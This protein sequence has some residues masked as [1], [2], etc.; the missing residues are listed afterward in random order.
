[1]A[2]FNRRMAVRVAALNLRQ[3]L[4]LGLT[5]DNG[6]W[7]WP[8]RLP[9]KATAPVAWHPQSAPRWATG[10]RNDPVV[11]PPSADSNSPLDGP[12]SVPPAA[13]A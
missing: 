7:G 10:G 5:I 1:M 13:I 6:N 3:L 8:E 2:A 9:S 11:A 4:A 12:G